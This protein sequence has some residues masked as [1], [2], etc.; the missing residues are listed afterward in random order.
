MVKANNNGLFQIDP[1]FLIWFA[2]AIIIFP[3]RWVLSWFCAAGIHELF[4]YS[5]LRIAGFRVIGVRITPNGAKIETDMEAGIFQAVCALAG[6]LSGFLMLLV[7]RHFP[8]LALC[9]CLQSIYNIIPIYPLDGGRAVL[10]ILQTI[11]E[12]AKANNIALAIEMMFFVILFAFSLYAWVFLHLGIIPLIF[13]LSVIIKNKNAKCT[14]KE[15]R[16]RLE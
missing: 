12:E 15:R 1:A 16:L 6:P 5:A 10:S 7:V 3:L 13:T 4:H 8:R 14:C 2:I 9:G 11:F